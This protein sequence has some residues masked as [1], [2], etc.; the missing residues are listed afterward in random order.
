MTDP[1]PITLKGTTYHGKPK[2]MGEWVTD[3]RAWD[4]T[5]KATWSS[6]WPTDPLNK[7]LLKTIL[8]R[9]GS[10]M[11]EDTRRE[12]ERIIAEQERSA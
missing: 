5:E 6:Q 7:D 9:H 11:R 10:K 3:P 1:R 4:D 8:K 12:Y 2:D